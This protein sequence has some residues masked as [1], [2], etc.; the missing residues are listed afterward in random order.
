MNWLERKK[1]VAAF[2]DG[3]TADSSRIAL[4]RQHGV[5]HVYFGKQE[6]EL[7]NF[8]P[9]SA[10]YLRKVWAVGEVAIFEVRLPPDSQDLAW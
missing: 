7:G 2:F 5:S 1:S 10:S 4:L 3:S 6:E 8:D 9:A